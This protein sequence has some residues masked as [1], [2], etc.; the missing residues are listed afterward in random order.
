MMCAPLVLRAVRLR[1]ALRI[2]PNSEGLAHGRRDPVSLLLTRWVA[3]EQVGRRRSGRHGL[4]HR[5][6]IGEL[7]EDLG[8]QQLELQTA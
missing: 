8:A 3:S 2:A 6:G 4:P 1:T 5:H 7:T